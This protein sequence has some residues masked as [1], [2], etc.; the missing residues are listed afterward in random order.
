MADYAK[1]PEVI[2]R[3]DTDEELIAR[4]AGGDQAAFESLVLRFQAPALRAAYRF[5]GNAHE[6]EDIAQE[7]LLQSSP[8]SGHKTR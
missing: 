1:T 5:L 6:A 8:D 7:T 3:P 2:D 4:V